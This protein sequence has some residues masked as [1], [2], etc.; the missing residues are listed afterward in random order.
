MQDE[1]TRILL[2]EG[3]PA[4][5]RLIGEMLAEAKDSAL[6]VEWVDRLSAGLERLSTNGVDVVLLDL[7]L[8]DGNGLDTVAK[9]HEQAPHVPIVV[10]TGLDDEAVAVEAVH[11]R[12]QDYLIKGQIE[13]NPL[14]RAVRHAIKRKRAEETLK[15]TVAELERRTEEL[16]AF[17]YSVSHDLKEPLRTLEAFSQFLLEDYAKRL[18]DQGRSYLTRMGKASAR[19]KQMIEDLLTLSRLGQRPQEVERIDVGQVVASIVTAMQ[20]SVDEKGAALQVEENLPDVC[21]DLHRVEQ[22]FG[23]LIANALKFNRS[24]RPIVKIGVRDEQQGMATFYVQ[25]NGIGIDPAY[26]DRIF[27]VFQQLHRREEYEGTGAGLAIVQRAVQ[28]LGGRV[29]VE[30]EAGAGA[31]FCFTLPVRKEALVAGR[32]QAA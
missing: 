10:F 19:L 22:V 16:E 5:A 17:T 11:A 13:R 30:S 27:G 23:N 8:P 2:I 28:A 6:S 7:G 4:D 18:D 15:R 32:Q 26:R 21:G 1:L 3:N 20:I 12:A 31:T 29:W 25:D 9:A 14:A 24:E